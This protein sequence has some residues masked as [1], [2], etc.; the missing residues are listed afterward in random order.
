MAFNLSIKVGADLA[1][2]NKTMWSFSNDRMRVMRSALPIADV[3]DDNF[4]LF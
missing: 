4:N 3:R 2:H 1:D